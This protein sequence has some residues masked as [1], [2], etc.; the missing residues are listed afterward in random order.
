MKGAESPDGVSFSLVR[1]DPWFCVQQAIG[2]IPPSGLGI[3]R[4][5]VVFALVT[6]V[7]LVIWAMLWRRAF[8]G[9]LAEPLLQR[10]III[11]Q[12]ADLVLIL[13]V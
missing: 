8:P 11:Q 7:P 4:R 13:V 1:G 3:V 6:W 5:S 10:S 12:H 9:E 2:L